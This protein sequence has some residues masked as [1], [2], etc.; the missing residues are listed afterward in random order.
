MDAMVAAK[1]GTSSKQSHKG[2][3]GGRSLTGR[4]R[5]A[6]GRHTHHR[7]RRMDTQRSA[8]NRPVK[9]H[10]VINI[11]CQFERCCCL[12]WPNS[13]VHYAIIG[14]TTVPPFGNHGNPWATMEM[15]LPLLCLLYATTAILVGRRRHKG[16]AVAANTQKVFEIVRP[17]SVLTFFLG[18]LK[19]ARRLQ[20]CVMWT[21]MAEYLTKSNIIK[22]FL[23]T[24]SA[25]GLN[26]NGSQT[27][28]PSRKQEI[29]SSKPVPY[30]NKTEIKPTFKIWT[31]IIILSIV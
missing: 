13:G 8:I 26:D 7:V 3:R 4:S 12:P 29:P 11:V 25:Y 27:N 14:A 16:R 5:E 15:I 18:P 28:S 1:F 21:L 30:R 2:C 31:S 23:T 6:G 10:T 20:P 19:A 9:K 17:M 24:C 22:I